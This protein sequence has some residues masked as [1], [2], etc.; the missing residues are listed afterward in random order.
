MT[1]TQEIGAVLVQNGKID[2]N[3]WDEP[4]RIRSAI[5]AL[6]RNG[7]VILASSDRSGIFTLEAAPPGT[8]GPIIAKSPRPARRKAASAP[9]LG[10][11]LK[12]TALALEQ[13]K[14]VLRLDGDGGVWSA[15]LRKHIEGGDE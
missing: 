9:A 11:T 10:A 15:V 6:R 2:A 13:G 1:L 7:W 5:H 8:N 4:R 3:E 14:V 12:V